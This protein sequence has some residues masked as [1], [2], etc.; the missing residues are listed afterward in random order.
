MRRGRK[1]LLIIVASGVFTTAARL[2]YEYVQFRQVQD[3]FAAIAKGNSRDEVI[4]LVGEPSSEVR[5]PNVRIGARHC[6]TAFVY[7]HPLSP[8][9][10]EQYV[11]TFSSERRVLETSHLS[12]K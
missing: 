10:H 4:R 5:C 12:G 3:H 9:F 7:S 11:V 6:S 2:S 8:I 1:A